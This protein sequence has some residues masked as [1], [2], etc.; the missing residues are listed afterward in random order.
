MAYDSVD[1]LGRHLSLPGEPQRIISLI[2]SITELLFAL[3]LA[4]RIAG[5][6]KFCSHP[7][8]GVAK[9]EKVGGQKN[10]NLQKILTL[11]P[12]LIIAN[13]EENRKEDV[14]VF[15][16]AGLPVYITYP[17]TVRGG[18]EMIRQLAELTGRGEVAED[19]VRPIQEVYEETLTLRKDR[20]PIKV[21]CPIWRKPYM[22]VNHDTYVHDVLQTCGGANIFAHRPDRYPKVSLAE[23]AGLTPD[24]ILL[25]DEPYPFHPRH[26]VDFRPFEQTIPALQAQRVHVIDGKLLSWYGPRIGNSLRVLRDLLWS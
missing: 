21:F 12:D 24:V 23:V 16:A 18:I 3:G 17:K 19:M 4:H 15:E 26:L 20:N 2:P 1:A 10:P 7:P 5:V 25:P 8:E 13:V 14:E 6:T 22:S 9:K 11:R